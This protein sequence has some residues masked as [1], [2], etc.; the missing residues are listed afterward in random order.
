[1]ALDIEARNTIEQF[2]PRKRLPF[3]PFIHYSIILIC[4]DGFHSHLIQQFKTV[5]YSGSWQYVQRI[6]SALEAVWASL[7]PIIAPFLAKR[8][9]AERR[10][11]CPLVPVLGA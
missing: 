8:A 9:C 2:A 4:G 1:M 7:H 10:S 6:G 3:L 5:S 11:L